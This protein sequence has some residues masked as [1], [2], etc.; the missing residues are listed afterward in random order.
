MGCAGRKR[1]APARITLFREDNWAA[2]EMTLEE[3]SDLILAFAQVLY[4]NGQSTDQTL[5]AA[6]QLGDTL[7]LRARILPRW[8]ELELQANDNDARLIS[9][10]AVDPTGVNMERVASA[11]QA[12]KELDT[13]RLAPGAAMTATKAIS[14][15]PPA[16]TWLFTLAA[17][18]GA[19]ALAVIFGV[20]HLPAAAL[21]FLSAAAGAILRRSVAQYSAN[22]FLQPFCAALLAG[23]IGALAVR[24]ELSSSLRLVAVCP[25]MV[26]VPG[27][28]VLNGALDL[29]KGRIH[30]G[31]ARMLYAVLIVV[32]ISAGLLFGLAL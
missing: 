7:G 10:V 26:L 12:I 9:T 24:Y 19:V 23:V 21:I 8:G 1:E 29:I 14:Q 3:R 31:A 32:A 15:T 17:A 6:A 27:P 13:G 5:A 20:Q 4:A 28:P 11:M 25:C 2:A 18:A 30:L 22:V 16:P